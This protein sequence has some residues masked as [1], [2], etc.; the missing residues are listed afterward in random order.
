MRRLLTACAVPLAL[1]ACSKAGPPVSATEVTALFASSL[2][3]APGDAAWNNAPIHQA[4]LVPQDMVEPRKMTATLGQV[5]VRALTDGTRVAFRLTWPDTT[6]DDTPGPARFGDACAVQVPAA[7][8]ADAPA[9]QMGD[10]ARDVEISFWSAVAQASADGRPDTLQALYPNATVDH[11]PFEAAP[12][13]A[14]SAEQ[15]EAATRYAPARAVGNPVAAAKASPVQ[16]LRGSGPGTLAPN[17]AG[18]S[19]GQGKRTKDGWSVVISRALPNGV[20]PGGRSQV[21]F[22]V[23]NGADQDA[24]ARKM[25]SVWIPLALATPEQR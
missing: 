3:A 11:Y 1:A 5:E 4:A 21:A 19:Q 9:P 8:G 14:G 22:A 12:L 24:G 18:N 6:Q 13:A 25:R 16:D 23:W 7:A 20:A 17:T 2:P 10:A 15:K